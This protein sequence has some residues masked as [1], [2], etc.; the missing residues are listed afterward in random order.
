MFLK[1]RLHKVVVT[2]SKKS[3]FWGRTG[4]SSL[5]GGRGGIGLVG[6]WEGKG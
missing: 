6:D 3:V 2:I 4:V 1:G 5:G